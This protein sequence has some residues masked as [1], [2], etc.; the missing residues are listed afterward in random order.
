MLILM[1]TTNMQ[2]KL[3]Y[4]RVN[5][6]PDPLNGDSTVD[7]NWYMCQG[8]IENFHKVVEKFKCQIYIYSWISI[9]SPRRLACM[10]VPK[11]C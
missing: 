9:Q 8:L 6:H 4:K 2:A 3:R 1:A 7:A 5:K 10:F 11:S